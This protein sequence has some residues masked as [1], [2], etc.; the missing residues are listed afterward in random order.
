M[1]KHKPHFEEDQRS[2]VGGDGDANP[3]RASGSDATPKPADNPAQSNHELI[4]QLQ[5]ERDEAVEGRL[6]VLADFRNYQR[7]ATENEERALNSGAAKV[8]KGMIPALDHFD[9]ALNQRAD[10]MSLKQLLAAVSIVRDEFNKALA[11]QGVERIEPKKGE[12]FDPHRHEA[13]MRQP[14]DDVPPN[15]VVSTLQ[16]GYALGDA[17]LRPA[18][19]SVAPS[20]EV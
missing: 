9:L 8:V 3:N 2:R 18:K 13:V 19:V 15:S 16:T 20:E 12:P 11:A 7:R 14:A 6:R 17:I 1:P 4:K 5:T 10:Q